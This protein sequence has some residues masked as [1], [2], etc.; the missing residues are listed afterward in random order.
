[1]S[2]VALAWHHRC[3]QNVENRV[4]GTFQTRRRT[5]NYFIAGCVTLDAGVTI[6]LGI[7][8][9]ALARSSRK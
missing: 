1:M 8:G 4:D 5:N 9:V 2:D 3:A 7:P 6:Y